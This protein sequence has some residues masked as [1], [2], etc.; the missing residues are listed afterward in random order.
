MNLKLPADAV[1]DRAS[2]IQHVPPGKSVSLA[3]LE[4][5]G[6]I[7]HIFATTNRTPLCSRQIII[8]I[9]FDDAKVP[10]VEAPFGDFFGVM[11][12]ERWYPINSA[13]L[14]VTED[15]AYNMYFPM[16]FAKSARIEFEAVG[17]NQHIYLQVDWHRY[18][19]QKMEETLRFCA[20]WR[21]ENPTARYGAD[22]L[23]LDAEG[24]GTLA[25]F[26]YGVRLLDNVD[27][28]SHGGADNIY[29]DGEGPHPAYLRGTGGEDTFGTSW[30][31]AL[32]NP[33]THLYA[34]MPYYKYEDVSQARAA[35][36]VVGYR[37]FE[38]DSISFRH[39]IHMRYGCMCNDICSTVYW[40]QKKPVRPF[41]RL[42]KWEHLVPKSD[43]PSVY[44]KPLPA[45]GAWW[46]C[47]P[48][49][50]S[51]GQAMN[52]TLPVET[53]FNPRTVFDGL[54]TKESGWL[55]EISREM[56]RDKARW[57]RAS[58]H[59]GFVDFRHFFRPC[60]RGASPTWPGVALARCRLK[61]T[62]ATKAVLRLSWD[63]TLFLRVNGGTS[64]SLGQHAAFRTKTVPVTLK[65]GKNVF[66]LK[67]SN[68]KGSNWGGWCFAF[69]A[70]TE[71]GAVLHPMA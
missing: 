8:R 30:G 62:A 31:G 4:G 42:P 1:S 18:P 56:G 16:P 71:E 26:V 38:E 60:M 40:Y 53:R 36:T 24:P 12:G 5:P 67:L 20:R 7:R 2:A 14:S 46:L 35:Q 22:Y 58:A 13:R 55:T 10:H 19:G 48:F 51:R 65:K 33:E 17:E 64:R 25:G 29:L 54:H 63:D 52:K 44:D 43:L 11:H 9:Y 37:F 41:F 59:H 21:R 23:M 39:S 49:D 45:N 27:R 57:V 66:L 61:T 34:A 28:W 50:N 70:E 15:N 69:S 6:C 68:S 3:L 47:G 32:H